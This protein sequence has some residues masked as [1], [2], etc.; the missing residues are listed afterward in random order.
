M[1]DADP[2]AVFEGRHL[3][4][5]LWGAGRARLAVTFDF[6]RAGRR[7]FATPPRVAAFDRAGFAQLSIRSAANDWFINPE[8][9]AL[10][11]RLAR[12]GPRFETVRAL[13]YSMGGYGAFRLA[14][15]LG[16]E[17]VIAVSPQASLAPGVVPFETRYP[18]EAARFSPSLGDL[19]VCGGAGLRGL[20]LLDP[21]VAEDVAHAR[22]LQGWFPGVRRVALPGGGHPATGLLAEA[23]M[24]RVLHHLLVSDRPTDPGPILASHKAARRLSA[25]YWRRLAKRAGTRHPTLAAKARSLATRLDGRVPSRTGPER[26]DGA[27]ESS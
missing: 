12:L 3:R 19:A 22:L 15:A 20:I 5:D 14:R 4:A 7:G 17:A 13:G 23:R 11:D 18:E 9:E 25:R 8:T 16:A 6:R 2:V 21:A 26:L 10:E 27:A 1:S 24:A